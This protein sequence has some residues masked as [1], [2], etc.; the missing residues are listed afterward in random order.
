LEAARR[1]CD[2]DAAA[3]VLVVGRGTHRDEVARAPAASLGL[4]SRMLFTGYRREDYDDVLRSIDVFTLLVPGSDGSCRAVLEAAACGIPA[5]VTR[6]GALPEIV[7][8]G[9]TGRVV[10]EDPEA[11]AGAWQDLLRDRRRRRAL[12]EAAARRARTLFCPERLADDV[13][14]LYARVLEG[15]R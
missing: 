1:L 14:A 6:R 2:H 10:E 12:G 4:A 5:V 8:D 11:L 3:R 9:E 13:E 7:V 15:T